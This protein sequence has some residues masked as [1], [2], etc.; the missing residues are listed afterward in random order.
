MGM[1]C[2]DK[3]KAESDQ[4]EQYTKIATKIAAKIVGLQDEYMVWVLNGEVH[5]NQKGEL[6]QPQDSP[7]VWLAKYC[8]LDCQL[9]NCSYPGNRNASTVNARPLSLKGTYTKKCRAWIRLK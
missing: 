9:G 7:Y 4:P 2:N 8:N 6:I 5:M 1:F 3:I